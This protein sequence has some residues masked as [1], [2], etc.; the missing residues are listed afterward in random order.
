MN[1][2]SFMKLCL[3]CLFVVNKLIYS[4]KRPVIYSCLLTPTS[5]IERIFKF[6]NFTTEFVYFLLLFVYRRGGGRTRLLVDEEASS[7]SRGIGGEGSGQAAVSG[8][9]SFQF[10]KFYHTLC[11][12]FVVTDFFYSYFLFTGEEEEAG[13]DSI[14]YSWS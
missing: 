12:F 7:N 5:L 4:S 6:S 1:F 3:L 2:L 8:G 14:L 11:H 9:T 13:P 10:F